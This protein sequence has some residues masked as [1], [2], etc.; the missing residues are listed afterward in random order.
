MSLGGGYI[1]P[2]S[3]TTN[4]DYS[5]HLGQIKTKA[6]SFGESDSDTTDTLFAQAQ[7]RHLITPSVELNGA[8]GYERLHDD[9]SENNLVLKAGLQYFFNNE[10]SVAAH[11]RNADEYSDITLTARYNF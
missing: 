2:L 8:I 6:T 10:V 1:Q 7:L 9:E 3:S 11:Y 4:L 5:L